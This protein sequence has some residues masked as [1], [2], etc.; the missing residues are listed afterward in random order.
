M[1]GASWS[2]LLSGLVMVGAFTLSCEGGGGGAFALSCVCE[3]GGGE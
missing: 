2:N 3:W 1:L